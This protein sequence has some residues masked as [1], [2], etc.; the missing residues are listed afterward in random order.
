MEKINKHKIPYLYKGNPF[1]GTFSLVPFQNNIFDNRFLPTNNPMIGMIR[2]APK[3]NDN[4]IDNIHNKSK[5]NENLQNI[6]QEN[7]KR[8]TEKKIQKKNISTQTDNFNVNSIAI[9]ANMI[10]TKNNDVDDYEVI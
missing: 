7:N 1:L 6:D 2:H 8:N 4:Y 5:S 3:I 9:Q 10:T